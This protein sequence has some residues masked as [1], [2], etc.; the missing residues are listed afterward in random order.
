M[1]ILTGCSTPI[2][3]LL[4]IIVLMG[5]V[6]LNNRNDAAMPDQEDI[7]TFN[8]EQVETPSPFYIPTSNSPTH[9]PWQNPTPT[10]TPTFD[11]TIYA[12][13]TPTPSLTPTRRWTISWTPR[14]PTATP[15]YTPSNTPTSTSEA[16]PTIC[17]DCP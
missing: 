7:D 8:N 3:L 9:V 11:P 17:F 12:M 4:A 6:G 10:P 5:Y 13:R 1:K 2:S 14:P 16:P 15:T